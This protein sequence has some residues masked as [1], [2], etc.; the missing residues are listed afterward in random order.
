MRAEYF[1]ECLKNFEALAEKKISTFTMLE[2]GLNGHTLEEVD[3]MLA[4][5]V[6]TSDILGVT[7]SGSLRLLLSQA[8]E[9]DLAFILPRFEGLDVTITVL[10]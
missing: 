8:S 10:K 2:F 1:A 9:K 5:K 4:G 6:R 7:D 3:A